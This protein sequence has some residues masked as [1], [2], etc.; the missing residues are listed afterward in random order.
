MTGITTKTTT[1][2]KPKR[3]Y[4]RKAPVVSTILS[5]PKPV[6]MLDVQPSENVPP[7]AEPILEASDPGDNS[8]EELLDEPLDI[9]VQEIG[10]YS[11]ELNDLMRPD[12]HGVYVMNRPDVRGPY[13][14]AGYKSAKKGSGWVVNEGPYPEVTNKGELLYGDAVIMVIKK[15]A[16]ERIM[17]KQKQRRKDEIA[18]IGRGLEMTHSTRRIKASELEPDPEQESEEE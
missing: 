4:I 14:S 7:V 15:T 1:T 8:D 6:E 2:R 16:F 3:K 18:G 11:V 13:D 5:E 12:L 9:D 17:A 10:T